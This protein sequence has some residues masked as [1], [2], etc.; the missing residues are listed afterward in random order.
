MY[1]RNKVNT[2]RLQAARAKALLGK[3]DDLSEKQVG[4]VVT[5]IMSMP[6]PEAAAT[7]EEMEKEPASIMKRVRIPATRY[8]NNGR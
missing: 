7:L 5:A 3:V 8:P 1:M 6:A 4:M 2:K